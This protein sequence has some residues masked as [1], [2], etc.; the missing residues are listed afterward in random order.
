VIDAWNAQEGTQSQLAERFKVSLSFVKRV[1]RRYRTSGQREAKS[2]GATLTPTIDR[3]A[4]KEVQSWIEQKPDILLEELCEQLAKH[5]G[6]KV[7]QPTM[8]RAVQRL[9]M[10]RKKTLYATEQDTPGVRQQRDD[11]RQWLEQVDVRNLVFIDEA[12]IHV[13]MVRLFARAFG[14]ERAV[15]TVPR[16]RGTNVSLIGALSLD[17]LIASMTLEGSVDTKSVLEL[18]P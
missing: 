8:C 10:P 6:I 14:G 13:G 2:R 3:E 15:D 5:Q 16:N 11:Y 4:L 18:C 17:G 7:S 1:L 9:K 12:G